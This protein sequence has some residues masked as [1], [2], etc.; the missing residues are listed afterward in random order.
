[1]FACL[2][3]RSGGV[4]GVGPVGGGAGWCRHVRRVAGLVRGSMGMGL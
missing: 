2:G 4:L 3:A 1:L